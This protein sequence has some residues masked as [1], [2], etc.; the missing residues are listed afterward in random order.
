MN[1]VGEPHLNKIYRH[2][3]KVAPG[4]STVIHSS[5]PY[6]TRLDKEEA[7]DAHNRQQGKLTPHIKL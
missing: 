7:Y 1:P 3:F 4:K 6:I 5:L 2:E